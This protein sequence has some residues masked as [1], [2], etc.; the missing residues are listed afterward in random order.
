MKSNI[1][2]R[3][4][5]FKGV[6][7]PIGSKAYNDIVDILKK[8]ETLDIKK[9]TK[10]SLEKVTK[11][12]EAQYLSNCDLITEHSLRN[13]LTEFN[14]RAWK[15]GLRSMPTMF[16]IM[17]AFFNYRKP[18][19]YFELIEEENYLISF[20]DFIDFVTSN[21]FK[22]SI[23]IIKE[24][25]VSDIIYNFNIGKDINEITF[26]SDVGDQFIVA[27][28][29]IIRREEEVTILMTTGRKQT[30]E[31]DI[32]KK[33]I[34]FDSNILNKSEILEE[35]KESL[36]KEDFEYEYIDENKEYIKV[37]V[38]CRIDLETLTIDA[39]YVA[40]ETN[41]MFK[42]TTDEIDGFLNNNGEFISGDI[43]KAYFNSLE[44][45]EAYNPIFEAIKLS[46]YLPYYFN[47]NEDS[48][49][50]E[51]HDTAFKKVNSYPISRK[52]YKDTFGYKCSIKPL[53]SLDI[54]NLFTPDKIKL[55]D[56]LFK[57]KTNGYWKKIP[58]ED[59]GLDKKGN[60]VHGKTWVNQSLS[61]FEAKEEDLIVKKET[62]LYSGGNAGF[63][64]ILRNPTMDDDIFKI[65]LTRYEVDD[66]VKQLSKTSV[67]DKFYKSQEW[68]VKDCVIAEKE[69]HERLNDYRVDP[70]REFF[71]IKYDEAIK[72]I[73][74]VVDEINK[75]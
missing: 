65:G 67:P 59:V 4:E 47:K 27:G 32:D 60:P 30:E 55:R 25:L 43:E 33:S 29:S 13:Y 45:I 15:Y 69:I 70:R 14:N 72:V 39:R 18:E 23:E 61:W 36:S 50:E 11:S 56:D 3:K 49:I 64:Y 48:I 73:K 19:I 38:A 74:D 37:L 21:D 16:N 5:I 12:L 17:E 68:N 54:K 75:K 46:L 7:P 44:E 40:E 9:F 63:I 28:V 10:K 71:K 6:I 53:F 26:N 20:F 2:R 62:E 57:I 31:I 66:R 51:D 34:I 52:K 41:L 1:D 24:N 22:E 35:A 58:I 42:I 8:R